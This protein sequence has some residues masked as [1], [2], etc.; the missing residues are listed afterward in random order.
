MKPAEEQAAFEVLTFLAE[1]YD[2]AADF[3]RHIREKFQKASLGRAS[4]SSQVLCRRLRNGVI[5]HVWIE[6]MLGGEDSLT[7]ELDIISQEEGWLVD[8]RVCKVGE[9]GT[10]TI[11]QFP[12]FTAPD[13]STVKREVLSIFGRLEHAGEQAM[14]GLSS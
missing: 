14:E 2:E 10:H 8:A 6:A 11:I 13:F 4:A 12:D 3:S 7:W 9:D 5:V 1:I